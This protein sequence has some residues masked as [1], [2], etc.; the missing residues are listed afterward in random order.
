M[1][2]GAP[3]ASRG[4]E[5]SSGWWILDPRRSLRARVAL[6]A[7]SALLV[8]T[9]PASWVAGTVL[10]RQ[11]ANQLG[12]DFENLAYQA[13]DKLDRALYERYREL[14]FTAGLA[15]LRMP[16]SPPDER[17]R[18]LESVM[19]ASPDYAW[20]GFANSAGRVVAATGHDLEGADASVR[21]W[22]RNAR[23]KPYSGDVH[24]VPELP[25]DVADSAGPP[26]FLDLSVP[27]MANSGQF[28]GALGAH[29]SWASLAS[30][31]VASVMPARAQHDRI[32]ITFYSTG[33][34]VLLDSGGSG[35]TEPFDAPVLPDQRKLRGFFIENT[36]N[37]ATFLTGYNRSRGYRDFRGFSW[38]IVVRQSVADAFAPVP[39]LQRRMVEAGLA[40]AASAAVLG[41]IF[42]SRLTRRFRAIGA[43]AERI[44]SGDVLSV[45]P[46]PRDRGEIS[47]MCAALGDM[48][49]QLRHQQEKLETDNTRLEARLNAQ[50]KARK[51]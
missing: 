39:L 50:D 41:W 8:V 9:L 47:A 32:G 18:L 5:T 24:E 30:D 34:A 16:S 38:L 28:L 33:S 10:R 45:L 40:L 13:G 31:V 17:R 20:I 22:F 49:D 11:I 26:R 48:V 21:N 25:P 42:A 1:M 15:P 29:L 35:W 14:Q 7:G 12:P 44:G 23:S 19:E 37:G 46:Q 3:S 51:A 36:P 4:P 43:S 6:A 27:V 2:H